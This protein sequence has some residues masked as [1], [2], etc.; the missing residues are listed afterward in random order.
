MSHATKPIK[1]SIS[2]N[3]PKIKPIGHFAKKRK[4]QI[5]IKQNIF[6]HIA[7]A[8]VESGK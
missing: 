8:E 4:H 3:F 1:I 7:Q 5:F 2:A 6:F